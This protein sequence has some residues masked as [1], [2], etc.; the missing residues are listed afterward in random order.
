MPKHSSCTNK[1]DNSLS[2]YSKFQYNAEGLAFCPFL[3]R[4]PEPGNFVA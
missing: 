2:V 4:D 3:S 1:Y